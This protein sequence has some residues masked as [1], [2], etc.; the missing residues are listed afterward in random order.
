[1]TNNLG[2][3][4]PFSGCCASL[5]VASLCTLAWWLELFTW[6]N[7]IENTRS[8]KEILILEDGVLSHS[9]QRPKWIHCAA[10][11]RARTENICRPLK[12]W[13]QR[14]WTEISYFFVFYKSFRNGFTQCC[15]KRL[16]YEHSLGRLW[17]VWVIKVYHIDNDV[18]P[19]FSR[20]IFLVNDVECYALDEHFW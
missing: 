14:K 8:S 17:T 12:S 11:A 4:L 9:S 15:L 13:S 5:L 10:N 1:M 7:K 19:N 3:F 2:D 16:V 6:R 20:N 18:K